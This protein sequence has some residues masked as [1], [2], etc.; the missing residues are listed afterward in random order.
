MLGILERITKGQGNPED[1]EKL[2]EMA[3]TIKNGALCALGGTAPNPVLTT[4]KY[5]QSEYEA[6]VYEKRCPAKQCKELINFVILPDKCTGCGICAKNCPVEAISAEKKMT[7]VIDQSK[8]TKCGTCIEHC[9]PKF[10]AIIKVSGDEMEIPTKSV[11]V[12]AIKKK[13]EAKPA[14]QPSDEKPA[15]DPGDEG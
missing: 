12:T 3:D 7:S 4:I 2:Q 1:I 5:F 6:H 13:S 10:S 11:P 8:C 14:E 9:P 15:D